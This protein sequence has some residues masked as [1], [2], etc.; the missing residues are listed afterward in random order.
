MFS[1][2]F[3][4]FVSRSLGIVTFLEGILIAYCTRIRAS[5]VFE[6]GNE[7]FL[8]IK[9]FKQNCSSIIFTSRAKNDVS[10]S[11]LIFFDQSKKPKL[12][13]MIASC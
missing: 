13:A 6:N 10:E 5:L 4:K 1:D 7:S 8:R 12:V 2:S 11:F 9:R 3:Y